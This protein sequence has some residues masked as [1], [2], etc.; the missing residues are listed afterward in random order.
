MTGDARKLTANIQYPLA[1]YML[2]VKFE[3]EPG[4]TVLFGSSGAGK[5]TV[6]N[7]LAGLAQPRG[8]EIRLGN[9]VLFSGDASTNV[10]VHQRNIGY[11]L[12]GLAL[13]PHMTVSQNVGYGLADGVNASRAVGEI[14]ERFRVPHLAAR[15]PREISG[16]ERQRVALARALVRQPSLLLLD[17]PMSALDVPTKQHIMDD[18]HDWNQGTQKIPIIYVTHDRAEV[19]SLAERVLAIEHGKIVAEGTPAEVLYAPRTAA[20]AQLAGFENIFDAKVLDIHADLGTATCRINGSELKLECPLTTQSGEQIRIGVRAGDILLSKQPIDGISAR[21]RLRGELVALREGAEF[22]EAHVNCCS[23][24]FVA[25][26]TRG[27]VREL[28]LQPGHPVW[29]ILKTH[30]C[31]VLR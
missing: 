31:H 28:A 23:V 14:L 21:N 26:L 9:D 10:A 20:M 4:V 30:S 5:T 13:F 11:L 27:A 2:D 6:L 16:G 19:F 25:H 29:L 1:Q 17:E 3:A 18:L 7:C 22:V 15:Y 24:V 12:Q 8:G